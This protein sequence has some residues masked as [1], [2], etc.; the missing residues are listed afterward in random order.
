M[1]ID[2]L[3]DIFKKISHS[4]D[5]SAVND[6]TRLKEDL[7]LDSLAMMLFSMEIEDKFK[8]HFTE[9]VVFETVKDVVDF[10]EK[11]ISE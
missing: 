6:D 9:P 4:I 7:H 2:D 5:V 3:K 10:I 11:K 1:V 8:F